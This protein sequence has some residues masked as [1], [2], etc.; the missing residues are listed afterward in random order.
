MYQH[1]LYNHLAKQPN[2]YIY[3]WNKNLLRLK[4]RTINCQ[5]YKYLSVNYE[6]Q[7]I[8]YFLTVHFCLRFF[9]IE[10]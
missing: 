5:N 6:I 3:C 1:E 4:L 7:I 8:P 2:L 9:L 10:A